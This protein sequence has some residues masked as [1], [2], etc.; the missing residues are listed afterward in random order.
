[1][2]GFHECSDLDDASGDGRETCHLHRERWRWE[3]NGEGVDGQLIQFQSQKCPLCGGDHQDKRAKATKPAVVPSGSMYSVRGAD[4]IVE[5]TDGCQCLI[6]LNRPK[7][8]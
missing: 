5:K 3:G 7:K 8:S 2:K 1:M 6:V 4:T